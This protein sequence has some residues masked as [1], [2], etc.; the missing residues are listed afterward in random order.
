MVCFLSSLQAPI[1]AFLRPAM[2]IPGL[3]RL[4]S[5]KER[6]QCPESAPGVCLDELVLAVSKA[7]ATD[8]INTYKIKKIDNERYTAQIYS[9]TRA[10]WLDVVE[11]EFMP[12]R[13]KGTEAEALSFSSG[14]LP[15]W[16]PLCFF[17]NCVLFFFPF[18]DNQFNKARLAHLRECMSI[19]CNVINSNDKQDDK[20]S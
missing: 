11:I 17:F 7:D 5:H 9:F 19:D 8:K 6:W 12:G 10:D 4:H 1:Q 3:N 18:Y 20:S 13:D 14:I 15:A 16:F 2:W